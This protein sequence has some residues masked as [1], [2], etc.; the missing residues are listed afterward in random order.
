LLTSRTTQDQ[1]LGRWPPRAEEELGGR[2]RVV[3]A[4]D[5]LLRLEG[6]GQKVL[7]EIFVSTEHLTVGRMT[8][9]PGQQTEPDARGGDEGLYLLEGQLLLR[10]PEHDGPRCFELHPGDGFYVPEGVPRQFFNYADQPA[11]LMFG[12]APAYLPRRS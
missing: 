2:L 5:A 10:L 4:R 8:L 6:D 3:T 11:R 7:V 9:Q 1:W 12:V